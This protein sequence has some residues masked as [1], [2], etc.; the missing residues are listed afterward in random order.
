MTYHQK[1][2][3]ENSEKRRM[4]RRA[5]YYRNLEKSQEISK[6]YKKDNHERVLESHRE[7]RR[8]NPDCDREYYQA[9][10]EQ[11][12]KRHIINNNKRRAMKLGLNEHFSAEMRNFVLEFWG[13]K[14]AICGNTGKLH[15]DHWLPLSGGNVLN[16]NNA[17]LMCKSCNLM[18]GAKDPYDVFTARQVERVETKLKEQEQMWFKV[19]GVQYQKI[20]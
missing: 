20:N 11:I 3:K 8:Q 19:E 7:Y 1:Y 6:K 15:F 17:V 18:K 16:M 2:Y 12:N 13:R 10:K 4:S 9:N 5:F 14:C